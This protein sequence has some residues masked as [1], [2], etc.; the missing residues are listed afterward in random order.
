MMNPADAAALGLAA[1]SRVTLR[2]AHGRLAGLSVALFDVA[3]GNLL[4]YFPEANALIG[5]AV[6]PRSRTPAF[7]SVAVAVEPQMA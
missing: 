2:S 4:M 1:G 3:P 5:T 6:D 7:K